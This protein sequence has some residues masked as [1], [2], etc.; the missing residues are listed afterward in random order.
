M[1]GRGGIRPTH[2][3]ETGHGGEG[4]ALVALRHRGC[5][6]RVRAGLEREC[7]DRTV[8]QADIEIGLDPAQDAISTRG[9]VLG[10]GDD[11]LLHARVKTGVERVDERLAVLEVDVEG[12]LGDACFGDHP[13]DAEASEAVGRDHRHAG[14]EQRL[15]SASA[16]AG[17]N[18]LH[19][20]A[21]SL[22]DR[23]VT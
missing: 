22:T 8:L 2:R 4:E 18:L 19:S 3:L 13:V 23:S 1:R 17:E 11:G 10:R 7:L 9:E 15:A 14:I 16:D 6:R 21:Q 20:H 12:A 5:E